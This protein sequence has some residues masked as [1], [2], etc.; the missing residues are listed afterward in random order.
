[1]AEGSLASVALRKNLG[2]AKTFQSASVLHMVHRGDGNRG[3]IR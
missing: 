1:M 2:P 3:S